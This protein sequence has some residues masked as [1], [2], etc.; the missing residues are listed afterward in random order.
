MLRLAAVVNS[1]LGKSLPDCIAEASSLLLPLRGL[2]EVLRLLLGTLL[3]LL[4]EAL[5]VLLLSRLLLWY[6]LELL[7]LGTLLVF[8]LLGTLLVL[9][10][11]GSLL[12]LLLEALLVL[13]LLGTL[14]RLLLEAL[15]WLL[16]L[17][18]LCSCCSCFGSS[19]RGKK[20]LTMWHWK[21]SRLPE[22]DV[23]ELPESLQ[24]LWATRL[25]LQIFYAHPFEGEPEAVSVESHC[26]EYVGRK[27]RRDHCVDKALLH[28]RGQQRRG[29]L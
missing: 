22:R 20:T 4:L 24:M 25:C 23:I 19:T 2:L 28:Q 10:L 7:L 16:L 29:C 11:L 15:L 8:L 12:R 3:R 9:L 6:L 26:S 13:L 18:L 1:C 5:L 21:L 14:L 17:W 27:T